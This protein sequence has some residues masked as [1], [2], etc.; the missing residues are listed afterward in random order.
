ML[1]DYS[2]LTKAYIVINATDNMKELTT[3]CDVS[4]LLCHVKRIFECNNDR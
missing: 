3:F 4:V 1:F 2:F